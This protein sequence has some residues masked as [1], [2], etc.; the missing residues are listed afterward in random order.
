MPTSAAR[1]YG[2][3]VGHAPLPAI[4]PTPTKEQRMP[5]TARFRRFAAPAVVAT[6]LTVSACGGGGESRAGSHGSGAALSATS[7][8]AAGSGAQDMRDLYAL[9][10][11]VA[12][13]RRAQSPASG[14]G[15]AVHGQ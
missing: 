5:A 3:G 13:F 8:A 12:A 7:T 11:D 9:K 4:R 10:R 15:C 1:S 14:G 6:A 2:D